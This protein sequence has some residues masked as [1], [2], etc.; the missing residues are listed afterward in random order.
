MGKIKEKCYIAFMAFAVA[1]M[2]TVTFLPHHH[3]NGML[4]TEVVYCEDDGCY[5]DEHT[6]HSHGDD[7][8]HCIDKSDYIVAKRSISMDDYV[9]HFLPLFTIAEYLLL[10]YDCYQENN[11]S[12]NSYRQPLYKSADICPYNILR[13]PPCLSV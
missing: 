5:N 10:D 3:H 6:G 8:T 11:H 12:K 7:N 2:L 4:C 13:G 9:E 1:V